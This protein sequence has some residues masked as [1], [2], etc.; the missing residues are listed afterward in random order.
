MGQATKR[1]LPITR[2]TEHDSWDGP[3]VDTGGVDGFENRLE[4][5]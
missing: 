5:V 1:E 3:L 4:D 2:V